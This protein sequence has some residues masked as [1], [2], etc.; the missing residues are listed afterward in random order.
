MKTTT[1]TKTFIFTK[2]EQ[3]ELIEEWF[4]ACKNGISCL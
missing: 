3:E 4:D 1:T 2:K